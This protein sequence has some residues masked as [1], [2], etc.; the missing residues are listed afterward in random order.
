MITT[1]PWAAPTARSLR[2]GSATTRPAVPR[3]LVR[4][5]VEAGTLGRTSGEDFYRDDD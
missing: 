4:S 1:G 3:D 5:D 2:G